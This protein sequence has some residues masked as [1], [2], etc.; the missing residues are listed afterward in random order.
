[1]SHGFEAQLLRW[2]ETSNGGA[3]IVLQLSDPDDLEHFKSMTLAKK[4]MVGQRLMVGVAEIGDDEL[5]ATQ[6]TPEE[7]AALKAQGAQPLEINRT[8]GGELSR[9]AGIWC[10]DEKFQ[11]WM[12][13]RFCAE[14]VTHV[15]EEADQAAALV[16]SICGVESR[17]QLD[18]DPDARSRFDNTI[19]IPYSQYL[20]ENA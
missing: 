5:P 4:G 12:F 8:K 11:K 3:T 10:G 17:A 13:A 20:K 19:R 7:R 16:R 9:L 1:M 14:G 2:A 18:H 6:W 15:G